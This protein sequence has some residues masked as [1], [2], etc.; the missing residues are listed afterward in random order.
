MES[1]GSLENWKTLSF[2]GRKRERERE[3]MNA[4]GRKFNAAGD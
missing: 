3:K 1:K 4:W 2:E